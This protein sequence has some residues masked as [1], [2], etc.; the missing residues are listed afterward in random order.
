MP[1]AAL[2]AATPVAELR[3]PK[4]ALT[5]LDKVRY[6]ESGNPTAVEV[7][8]A[9]LAAAGDLS[10]AVRQQQPAI[11]M[12]TG[13]QWELTPLNDRLARYQAG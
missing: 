11:S 5:L 7:R 4:R 12:A 9:A 6:E 13:L 3:A 10:E 2:L 8:A 1:L